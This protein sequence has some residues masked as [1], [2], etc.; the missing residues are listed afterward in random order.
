MTQKIWQILTGLNKRKNRIFTKKPTVRCFPLSDKKVLRL[1]IQIWPSYDNNSKIANQ[2]RNLHTKVKTRDFWTFISSTLHPRLLH[3]VPAIVFFY[4]RFLFLFQLHPLPAISVLVSPQSC[5]RDF[6][7]CISST[8][9]PRFLYLSLNDEPAIPRFLYLNWLNL[10]SAISVLV[11]YQLNPVPA[12]SV[13]ISA[14]SSTRDLCTYL[15][16]IQ[17][18]QF[19]YLS[20]LNSG[21]LLQIITF[22]YS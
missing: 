9:Y 1:R 4:P 14:K 16:L 12:I 22:H 5:T 2:G 8:L 6:C 15:G 10:V 11:L 17:Y 13:L 19:L 3:P 18:P 21:S 7:S 20:Q